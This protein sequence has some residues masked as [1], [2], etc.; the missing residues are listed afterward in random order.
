VSR[1]TWIREKE[2]VPKGAI[3]DR[4][5]YLYKGV[6]LTEGQLKQNRK[7]AREAVLLPAGT[8]LPEGV[9]RIRKYR[10]STAN[11]QLVVAQP[12]QLESGL[13]FRQLVTLFKESRKEGFKPSTWVDYESH[14]DKYLIPFLGNRRIVSLRTSDLQSFVNSLKT[15]HAK[16]VK[17][18]K[19]GERIVSYGDN[20]LHPRTMKK[21]CATFQ[22]VW[23]FA[24]KQQYVERDICAGVEFPKT[25]KPHRAFFKPGE[26]EQIIANT[27]AKHRPM[28]IL[29]AESGI[30]RGELMGLRVEDIMWKECKLRIRNNRSMDQDT[31]PKSGQERRMPVSQAVIGLLRR[32]IGTRSSGYVFLSENGTPI[33]LRNASRL[34]DGVLEAS[35]VKRHGLG[36]HSFRRYRATQLAKAGVPEAHRLQWMGHA[37]VDVDNGY[38]DTDEEAFQRQMVEKAGTDLSLFITTEK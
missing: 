3:L 38:V 4:A 20:I 6:L 7:A 9:T 27:P 23:T 8:P 32:F 11:R 14:L 31:D 35:G 13:T 15:T 18:M 2:T 30:R 12:A 21:M 29:A 37:D 5:Y 36:W 19:D 24:R 10:E 16:R 28:M 26:V 34:L 25:P 17:T 33:G 1:D 22:S